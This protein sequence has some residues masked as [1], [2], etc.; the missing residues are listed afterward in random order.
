MGVT[1]PT[2]PAGPTGPQGP[3]GVPGA[4]GAPGA[5]SLV[6]LTPEPMSPNCPAG[7]N[8][9][10]VGVDSN[11]NGILDAAEVTQTA[12]VCKVPGGCPGGAYPSAPGMCS[13]CPAG[14]YAGA[15]ALTCTLCPEGSYADMA[16]MA[17]CTVCPRHSLPTGVGATSGC[18]PSGEANNDT[19]LP[20][21][22]D[23]CLLWMPASMTG[24]P[25]QTSAEVRA[26]ISEWPLTWSMTWPPEPNPNIIAEIGYGPAGSSPVTSVSGWTFFPA[27]YDG[28]ADFHTE[29]HMG[30][31][32]LPAP[33]SYVY[34]LRFSI[35]GRYSYTYCDLDAAG[36]GWTF[37]SD[38]L[39]SLVVT[40]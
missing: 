32:P 5:I 33:G 11:G 6:K 1:G 10:D 23:H 37:S 19:D 25:G 16:G 35:D 27:A 30:T 9:V 18:L 7:G 2:G 34:T 29:K 26:F 40:P 8:R 24:T 36:S 15:G 39:G 4:M 31:F 13:L 17:A 3:A 14:S 28:P 21:E 20:E 22:L 12:Y 38:Q